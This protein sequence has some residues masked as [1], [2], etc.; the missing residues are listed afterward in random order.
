[1]QKRFLLAVCFILGSLSSVWPSDVVNLR[2]NRLAEAT[3]VQRTARF[4]WQIV[5]DKQ[6]VTQVAYA[7]TAATSRDGL[8]GG[9]DCLWQSGRMEGN[10]TL[11]VPYQ[12]R[13]LPNQ[14]D[15]FWRLEVWLSDGEY[16]VS[17]VQHFRTG[18][19]MM[20]WKGKWIGFND[21]EHMVVADDRRDLPARYLRREFRVQGKVSRALLYISGMGYTTSYINGRR[22][23]DDVFGTVL[24]NW[25]KTVYYNTYDVTP[26]VQRGDN[27]LGVEL[28][29][30]YTLGLRTSHATFG[31]PRLSAQLWVETSTDTLLVVSDAEWQATNRGP[32]R[33]N[34]LYDG[35]LYDARQEL[36]AWT[37]PGYD[38][39]RW[40]P[41]DI[42]PAPRGMLEAQPCPGIRTQAEL[43]P[44]SV[45]QVADGRWIVDMGQNMV[46]Q[47]RAT[48]QANVGQEVKMR[49][50]ERLTPDSSALYTDNLRSA[51]C[52]NTYI[53][54]RT[55]IFTYQPSTVYQGFRYVE[56]SGAASAPL[57]ENL[58]GCV[59]YDAMR[60]TSG[61]ECD[62]PLLNRLHHMAEWG[63]KGNYHGMPTDC[64]QRDERLG[65]T[66]DRATGCYGEN[67][68]FDN[69]A[70]YYKWLR[71]L[72]DTQNDA[73]QLADIAPEFIPGIRHNNVTWTGAAVY[74]VY[75]LYT[76][77]GDEEAVFRYYPFLKRWVQYTLDATQREGVMTEDTY[78]D[79][80]MPP[81]REDLIH[82]EDP[83]R[84]TEG[85]VL[86]TC[87]F[88]DILG[89]MQQMALQLGNAAD[90]EFYARTAAQMKAA[91]NKK[92]FNPATAQYSNN[93]VTANVLSLEL[94]LVPQGFEE[95]VL[96]NI[97]SVTEDKFDGHVSCGVLGIQH[98]MRCLSRRGHTDLAWRIVNQ[99]T[100]PSYGY[101]MAHGATTLWE[102]WNGD[103]A[104]PAMNSGNHVMLLGDLL[105]WYYEDLAGIRCADGERG[106][107][108][109]NMAPC[110]PADLH[111]VRAWYDSASGMIRS[112]WTRQGD[113]LEW[114]VEIPANTTA[115][116]CIPTRFN[117]QPPLGN[118]VHS[119]TADDAGFTIVEIGSGK[120]FFVSQ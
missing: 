18:L 83:S 91:Y 82:S 108:R 117:I 105:L 34:N 102:L 59:Q 58:A 33:R 10:A 68:L 97:V 13:R 39:S 2:V 100:Y 65:W 73:G 36:G 31:G 118:G 87:V 62:N 94:G 112:E 16:I 48:L 38:A 45:R 30:G 86:S 66:G 19:R 52:T 113:R 37:E 106:F 35:E 23:S 114:H 79:W 77:C 4:S 5:S 49:F 80:C 50:A 21:M 1:M 78:G 103:T 70:L 12:G 20:D 32:I 3:G 110:F 81:E 55:G 6:D 22:V 71:D 75:M 27:A 89:K 40:R 14:R 56:I 24:S 17:P 63:I 90:A 11:Q 41:A 111:H 47:L 28:G 93:T 92:F 9:R 44:Q 84:R 72:Q 76:R 51:L 60:A 74:A 46:G 95:R 54:A 64:P 99:Q 119:V 69:N 29:N 109:L 43:H 96:Q 107:S 85:A 115:R 15:I 98:L 101:M 116:V 42:L 57:A 67:F 120:Y 53:P 25:D 26:L 7:I 88:Y 104:N 8:K 61:F